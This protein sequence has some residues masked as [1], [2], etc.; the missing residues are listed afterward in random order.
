[1]CGAGATG[2]TCP[3]F[4]AQEKENTVETAELVGAKMV[5]FFAF[6]PYMVLTVQ[7]KPDEMQLLVDEEQ[8]DLKKSLLQTEQYRAVEKK[9]LA[10]YH[11]SFGEGGKPFKAD[12]PVRLLERLKKRAGYGTE[13]ISQDD[14]E[15]LLTKQPTVFGQWVATMK[16][17]GEHAG[18][19][20][21]VTEALSVSLMTELQRGKIE[22]SLRLEI[23]AKVRAE[24]A[25]IKKDGP[26]K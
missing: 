11:I 8:R 10:G 25:G 17:H 2:A 23:E 1:M 12:V 4:Q 24:L 18:L 26:K 3:T 7:V 19:D 5:R 16:K 22:D 9:R 14:M 13:F 6:V 15:D 20:T 21:K